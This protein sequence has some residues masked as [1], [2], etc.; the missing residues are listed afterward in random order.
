MFPSITTFYPIKELCGSES[1]K[2]YHTIWNIFNFLPFYRSKIKSDYKYEIYA[3][4]N[5][6][7]LFLMLFGKSRT[8]L[9]PGFC[10]C[11]RWF[12]NLNH[13]NYDENTLV[14][15][16]AY[17]N[18]KQKSAKLLL[19]SKL[20]LYQWTQHLMTIYI[21]PIINLYLSIAWFLNPV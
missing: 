18:L 15:Q 10:L 17:G 12:N 3:Y 1:R 21:I 9:N 14:W 13:Y 2:K 5:T 4:F 19:L 7:Q 11:I 8:F 16:H 20:I 6:K